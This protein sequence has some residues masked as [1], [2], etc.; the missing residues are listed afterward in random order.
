MKRPYCNL[1][2]ILSLFIFII[3]KRVARTFFKNNFV[4]KTKQ[5]AS[6]QKEH[7]KYKK[8]NKKFGLNECA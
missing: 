6:Q 1:Y 4:V 8:N 3:S 5:K 7:G 2:D